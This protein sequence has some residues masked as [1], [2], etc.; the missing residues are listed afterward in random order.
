MEG[1]NILLIVICV[2]AFLVIVF[3]IALVITL[4]KNGQNA[5]ESS[6]YQSGA[7]ENDGTNATPKIEENQIA[8][9]SYGIGENKDVSAAA[10]ET[11]EP[12]LPV[13]KKDVTVKPENTNRE[14]DKDV[15]MLKIPLTEKRP[16]SYVSN[17][18]K[19]SKTASTTKP[20]T[21]PKV[22]KTKTIEYWIQAGS[23]KSKGSADAQNAKLTE[24][25]FA[26]QITTKDISGKTFFRVKIGP[27]S[28][29]AEAEK[30][31]SWVKAIDGMEECYISQL[32]TP[33]SVN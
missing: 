11:P 24:H 9:K 26:G 28:N 5:K 30:F 17:E 22:K 25:G 4:P 7:S 29:K 23:Y 18:K 19:S 12:V 2:C 15:V 3:G 14:S 1:K 33:K 16:G 21:E 32:R 13:D 8:D 27:Y 31:L 20:K 6:N 10:S